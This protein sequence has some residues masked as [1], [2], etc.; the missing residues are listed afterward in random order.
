MATRT[1]LIL[2]Q[3]TARV[4][5]L[6]TT[7]TFPGAIVEAFAGKNLFI[8]GDFSVWQRG[9]TFT[10]NAASGIRFCADRWSINAGA[11]AEITIASNLLAS[12]DV[13]KVQSLSKALPKFT[14]TA[15]SDAA[16]YS[17]LEQRIENVHV[18]S[19]KNAV[20]SFRVY[21]PA[22]VSRY[23]AVELSQYFRDAATR[24]GIGPKKYLVNPGWN[25]IV[26]PVAVP[27][28]VGFATGAGHMLD[29]AIWFSCGS[30]WNSRTDN[31][32]PQ[33]SGDIYLADMQIEEG[34]SRTLFDNRHPAIELM[35]C[36]RYYEKSYNLSTAP[37][38]AVNQGREAHASSG[39]NGTTC[40]TTV[41]FTQRKRDA[42]AVVIYPA[43]TTGGNPGNVA[44]NDGS[45][46]GAAIENIGSSG[47]QVAWGNSAGKFGGWFHWT[48][49]A[50][51]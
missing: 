15:S 34:T 17:L 38:S 24:I 27:S 2:N 41:R 40:W 16:H 21:L 39:V 31:L 25:T 26:H 8:N 46:T 30:N 19:G 22:G 51:L 12:V 43:N 49:D 35:L 33:P 6:A 13:D 10:T 18:L 14:L 37:G 44:Q 11:G 20:V 47:M 7:D 42:P 5:E 28:T 45:I 50:E 4:E 29:V 48:A 9:T 36:Q 23:I 1:P 3:T 32:G